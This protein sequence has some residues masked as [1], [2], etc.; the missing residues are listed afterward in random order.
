MSSAAGSTRARR[1]RRLLSS[2]WRNLNGESRWG[3]GILLT[4]L[5][6]GLLIPRFSAYDPLKNAGDEFMRPGWPYIFGTDQLGRD[7]FTRT[8]AAVRLDLVLAFIGVSAPLLIGTLLGGILGTTRNPI[9][10][11]LWLMLIDAINA[12]PFIVIVIALVA[13]FGSGAQGLLIGLALV[14]WAR[15]ARIARARALILRE[16]DFIHAT[17]V[18]GYSRV[19]VLVQH[20]LPNVYAETLAYGLSDFVIVIIAI[21]GLSFLGVGVRPPEPEWGAMMS[22]GRSFLLRAW[23]ITVFPG[24]ILSLTAIGIAL[25]AQGLLGRAQGEE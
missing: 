25:L 9:V 2:F 10:S 24:L 11:S 21:A 19:R 14:N 5:L 8:F 15:Y 4:I 13:V 20:I 22:D 23:W 3:L 6:F 16:A 7:V 1:C 17:Q 12:F 18:L